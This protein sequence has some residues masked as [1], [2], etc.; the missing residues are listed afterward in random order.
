[1][2]DDPNFNLKQIVTH[3]YGLDEIQKGFETAYDKT[4]GSVKVQ[5]HQD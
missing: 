5:I 3:V 2:F 4:T 1:M